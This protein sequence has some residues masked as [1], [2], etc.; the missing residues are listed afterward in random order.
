M[1]PIVLFTCLLN[2]IRSQLTGGAVPEQ[3]QYVLH[4]VLA[5]IA[6]P[7]AIHHPLGFSVGDTPICDNISLVCSIH[8]TGFPTEIV[9]SY[10]TIL[11]PARPTVIFQCVA[12]PPAQSPYSY[13]LGG[14]AAWDQSVLPANQSLCSHQCNARS[15]CSSTSTWSTLLSSGMAVPMYMSD[16]LL[17]DL[18]PGAT[19]M[20][21][22]GSWSN[23]TAAAT[24]NVTYN[25]TVPL[26]PCQAVA[27]DG[28]CRSYTVRTAAI[29]ADLGYANSLTVPQLIKDVVS[30]KFDLLIHAGDFAYDFTT[31]SGATGNNYM[32]MMEPATARLPYSMCIILLE[33]FLLHYAIKF[34][35]CSDRSGEPR[36]QVRL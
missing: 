33:F 36:V 34:V 25:F 14:Q 10:A 30:G 24:A 7:I 13:I 11:L 3:I 8:R 29:V 16:V 26:L 12:P 20:Y 5:T 31:T 9:V 4:S 18:L 1:L 2:V 15:V 22:P 19:Y 35:C 28:S 6:E 23:F 17:T 21:A 32:N 27:S